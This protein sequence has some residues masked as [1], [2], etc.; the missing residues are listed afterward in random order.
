MNKQAYLAALRGELAAYPWAFDQARVDRYMQVAADA[1]A[2]KGPG[3]EYDGAA[4][5]RAWQAIGGRN[6]PKLK[7]LR[8]LPEGAA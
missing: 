3:F 1:L 5:C 6:R 8:A 4:S 7:E 2:G